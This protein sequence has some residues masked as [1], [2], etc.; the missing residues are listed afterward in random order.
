MNLAL[1][2]HNMASQELIQ[3]ALLKTHPAGHLSELTTVMVRR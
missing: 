1:E 3:S 2:P